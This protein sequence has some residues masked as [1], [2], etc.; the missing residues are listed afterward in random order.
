MTG[1]MSANWREEPRL[2]GDLRPGGWA[3][4][5]RMEAS[6]ALPGWWGH[7]LSSCRMRLEGVR[8]AG[9]DGQD[10][11][12][13]RMRL[14]HPTASSVS[15]AVGLAPPRLPDGCRPHPGADQ[16]ST[17]E[18][19]RRY[20]QMAWTGM[21]GSMAT[22]LLC[23]AVA[24]ASP[25]HD[26]R[27]AFL[28][29]CLADG[30]IPSGT[31]DA[32]AVVAVSGTAANKAFS[33][34]AT[35]AA[36]IEQVLRRMGSVPVMQSSVRESIGMPGLSDRSSYAAQIGQDGITA[37]Q[38]LGGGRIPE[39]SG[40]PDCGVGE[41]TQ[42]GLGNNTTGAAKTAL[43]AGFADHRI[44]LVSTDPVGL[45]SAVE[46]IGKG[47]RE[48]AQE[49]SRLDTPDEV[50]IGYDYIGPRFAVG[51]LEQ[52]FRDFAIDLGRSAD[53]QVAPIGEPARADRQLVQVVD[54]GT[55]GAITLRQEG[56]AWTSDEGPVSDGTS[57]TAANGSSYT[58][59]YR[60]GH[61][62]AE[63]I[64]EVRQI[65]G[66][67]LSATWLEDRSGYRVGATA[68][69][70]KE[71]RG[72]VSVDG[73]MYRVWEENGSLW[74]ARFDAPPHGSEP[75]GGHY[76]ID[77]RGQVATLMA[78]DK[79]TPANEE[80]TRIRV[81]GGDFSVEQLLGKGS[82][83]A[84]GER[85]VP[86]V[87]ADIV[88]LRDTA[89]ALL[90]AL[91]NDPRSRDSLKS[92]LSRLWEGVVSQIKLIFAGPVRE[93]KQVSDSTKAIERG[94]DV[95]EQFDAVV[96]ALS[97]LEA[98]KA[99]TNKDGE[100]V[101]SEAA[102]GETGAANVFDARISRSEAILTATGDT[103]HG[104]V[105]TE[106]RRARRA[107]GEFSLRGPGAGAGVFAYS[108]IPDTERASRISLSGDSIYRGRT[109]AVDGEGDFY[110]ANIELEVRFANNE[111]R[112]LITGL[113]SE[114]G[115]PWVYQWGEVEA[116]FLPKAKLEFYADWAVRQSRSNSA[117]VEY[118]DQ[119]TR[120][121]TA[122]TSSFDGHLLGIG[123]Q[124]GH[125]AVGSWSIGVPRDG[126][127]YLAGAF[128]AVLVEDPPEDGQTS[129]SIPGPATPETT[130]LPVGSD[131]ENGVL[132]LAGTLYG[133]NSE[134]TLTPADWDDEV[135]LLDEGRKIA[136]VY[137]LPLEE[138][139]ARSGAERSYLGSNLIDLGV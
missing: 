67:D 133:P 85:I 13:G 42:S 132:T 115:R 98:F 36:P 99:A 47:G 26:E 139:F 31:L 137:E 60:Y 9:S 134:T 81:G 130:A 129:P 95:I 87:L 39:V 109:T 15:F 12:T 37:S 72:D 88:E 14:P 54:L 45:M 70:S 32:S 63:L 131:I 27:G 2:V 74:G 135:L 24:T 43:P 73:V 6:K 58:L 117:L 56:G 104:A 61:W 113:S 18:S 90:I 16:A 110:T 116:V 127:E 50:P 1:G 62:S 41:P 25:G 23:A 10:R 92:E 78:D 75:A 28:P 51:S 100:G 97:S 106:T 103:R 102:K 46:R 82:A 79:Q 80:G 122:S 69:L 64:P 126:T 22:A 7:V 19:P 33:R 96:D 94:V 128:G 38:A 49:R 121:R 101:F 138:A 83:S 93:W 11:T 111:V 44:R 35:L 52:P 66:T 59:R 89:Q 5:L 71:G 20:A 108:T 68:I 34:E 114:R 55:S 77:L 40:L 136:D 30:G 57:I 53:P 124:A 3:S 65:V 17:S 123:T 107:E 84:V 112:G 91:G 21:L 86:D 120:T 125:Q 29:G 76:S 105:R 8:K 4:Q 48:L 118:E 119:F